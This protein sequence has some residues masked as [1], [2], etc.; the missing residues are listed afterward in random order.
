VEHNGGPPVKPAILD[1]WR[2]L[3][4]HGYPMPSGVNPAEFTSVELNLI[5][6]YGIWMDA[7]EN[8]SLVPITRAQEQFLRVCRGEE[9]PTT[10]FAIAWTK[11]RT[12]ARLQGNAPATAWLQGS[13]DTSPKVWSVCPACGGSGGRNGKCTRCNGT[14]WF[15]DLTARSRRGP[16]Q[17]T[18]Q[19]TQAS[20]QPH[21][22]RG[23]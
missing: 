11:L 13:D 23:M 10:K 8:Q 2:Y 6:K 17:G 18:R 14:G 15:D 16:V 19:G 4:T 5:W 12:A 3:T 20:E 9:E 1:H 7:L 22:R 21:T